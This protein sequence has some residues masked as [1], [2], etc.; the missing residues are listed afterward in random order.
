MFRSYFEKYDQAYHYETSLNLS[1]DISHELLVCVFLFITPGLCP[2]IT[3][4]LLWMKS[5]SKIT[6][7]NCLKFS[8]NKIVLK[9]PVIPSCNISKH[10]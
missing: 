2:L 10:S 9:L 3:V 1:P 7:P 8:Q 4:Q 6:L 5:N